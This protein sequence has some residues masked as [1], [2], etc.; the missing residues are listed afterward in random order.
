MTDQLGNVIWRQD[1]YAFGADYNTSATGNTHKFTGHVKDDATG[2]YYAKARYFTTSLG[3]FSQPEPLLKGVPGNSFLVNPQKLN[4]YVYCLNNPVIYADPDGKDLILLNDNSKT[5]AF[6]RGHSAVLVGNKR[7]W[8]YFSKDG[9]GQGK[10]VA[11]YF[12]TI[13]DFIKSG[14]AERYDRSHRVKT[15]I[16]QDIKMVGYGLQN[17]NKDYDPSEDKGKNKENCADL[18]SGIGKAGGLDI[19]QPKESTPIGLVTVPNAQYDNFVNNSQTGTSESTNKQTD[20]TE[21]KKQ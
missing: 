9:F 10:N 12:K 2:Q 6:G 7:G 8:A 15:D 18:V 5:T 3:R 14:L 20:D 13:S 21:E 1:Y 11:R 17:I 4:P 19:D 16:K